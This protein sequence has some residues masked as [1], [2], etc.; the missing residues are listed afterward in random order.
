MRL[1]A[2]AALSPLAGCVLPVLRPQETE[3]YRV[4]PRAIAML[5]RRALRGHACWQ[6]GQLVSS[7]GEAAPF[8]V[9]SI[10]KSVS[11]LLVMRAVGRGWVTADETVTFPEW[12]SRAGEGMTLRHLL[13]SS[14]GLPSGD[15]ALYSD[16]PFDKGRAAVVLRPVDEPGSVFRYGPAPW[17]LM[18]EWLKRRLT[19]HG[20]IYQ[21]FLT[22]LLGDLGIRPGDWRRDGTGMP[23]LST[24]MVCGLDDLGRL[25]RALSALA[26]GRDAAGVKAEVFRD[27]TAPRAANPVFSAGIWW[28]RLARL[29]TSRAVEPERSLSGA[30]PAGFW[31]NACLYPA[32]RPEWL[33]LV[34][35][36]G[37]RVYALPPA[38]VVVA[39]AGG[40][41]RWSDAAM[42][43]ALSDG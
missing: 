11:A 4:P 26:A 31:R 7:S 15:R 24:G 32:A 29:R 40:G 43:R 28:N 41:D 30:M 1:L 10:T 42:L 39:I 14:A 9:L 16:R 25:G 37:I 33:A 13:D 22:G 6:A 17:E 3:P 23:Y 20:V 36:G 8:P 34:G 18:G 12:R 5:R 27:L 2:A 35:S 38:D 21:E 19:E